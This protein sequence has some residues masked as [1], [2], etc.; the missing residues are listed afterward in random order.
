M[1]IHEAMVRDLK[2]VEILPGS[3]PA[4]AA[5]G[6]PGGR[7]AAV[8]RPARAE[9]VQ[10]LVQWAGGNGTRLVPVSSGPPHCRG[11]GPVGEG[12]VVV[13]F[14]GMSGILRVDRKN[15][16]VMVEPGVR[17]GPLQE[18]ARGQGLR[19]CS[20]LAPRWGKSVLAAC[21]E[22]EPC[23]QP[24]FQW[25]AMDPLC[26]IEVVLGDGQVFR[27]GSAAG[28][29]SLEQQWR[30]GDAQKSN[31]GPS[32]ADFGR[33]F[34]GAQG[35]LGLAVWGS[36]RCEIL[37]AIQRFHLV[38]AESFQALESAVHWMCR[39]K[40]G[41]ELFVLSRAALSW[42]AAA[43]A[44]ER[45]RLAPRLPAWTLVYAACG[46]DRM[47][48][49][50]VRCQEQYSADVLKGEGLGP[51]RELGGVSAEELGRTVLR[52]TPSGAGW[53]ARARGGVEEV[54]FES[55]FG[56]TPEFVQVVRDRCVESGF[57]FD[58]VGVYVQPLLGGR[59]AHIEF[60]LPFDPES[61]QDRARAAGVAAGLPGPLMQAG[62]FFSRPYGAWAAHAFARD[63]AALAA[64][65]KIKAIFD[66]KGIFSPARLSL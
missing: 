17:Y 23:M 49:K 4:A 64:T 41:D 18:A 36:I 45:E 61:P 2:G 46:Y 33:L 6:L 20:P 42:L 47:P 28:P 48:E 11:T 54:F 63:P 51:G 13:D 34:Q 53:R 32:Q 37:P 16:V 31:M 27:T 57:P 8:V 39:K 5:M 60:D 40:L 35:T 15:R 65:R 56:R 24:K 50:R 10:K 22:R 26:C 3:H 66:P 14:S 58:Q 21:L 9:Q 1:S 25:D 29:G 59:Y 7:P 12:E 52:P 19:L 38:G 43:G 62:A 30:S 55:F 44:P